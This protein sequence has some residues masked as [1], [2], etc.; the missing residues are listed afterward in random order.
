MVCISIYK[1]N[2]QTYHT[3]NLSETFFLN[4][5]TEIELKDSTAKNIFLK[6]IEDARNNNFNKII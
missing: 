4:G 1:Q 2:E 6:S 5:Y 3:M